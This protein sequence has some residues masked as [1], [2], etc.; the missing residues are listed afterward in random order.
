MTLQGWILHALKEAPMSEGDVT[1]LLTELGVEFSV[2]SMSVTVSRL[3]K[4][5]M[6]RRKRNGLL[7]LSSSGHRKVKSE[8]S[9]LRRLH[10]QKS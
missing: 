5:G 10:G 8:C 2:G 1:S 9:M 3:R 6:I 7:Y 4:A